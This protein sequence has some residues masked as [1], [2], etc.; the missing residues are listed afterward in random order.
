MEGLK[1]L[2]IEDVTKLQSRLVGVPRKCV[3]TPRWHQLLQRWM[4][5]TVTV[6]LYPAEY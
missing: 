4:E 2:D 3:D 6:T 1:G 5:G